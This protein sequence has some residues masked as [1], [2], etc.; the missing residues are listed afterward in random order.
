MFKVGDYPDKA[1]V[2]ISLKSIKKTKKK[3]LKISLQK[4]ERKKTK[5]DEANKT[6]IDHE[7]IANLATSQKKTNE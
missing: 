5:L 3:I 7:V 6:A 2:I 4:K 1:L